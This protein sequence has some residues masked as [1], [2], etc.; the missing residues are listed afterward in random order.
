MESSFL[1]L[2]LFSIKAPEAAV[3]LRV[4]EVRDKQKIEAASRRGLKD[5]IHGRLKLS[6]SFFAAQN[7]E[8]PSIRKH[9]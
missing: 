7:G 5:G 4:G 9:L 3:S 6:K 2:T 8:G 1:F